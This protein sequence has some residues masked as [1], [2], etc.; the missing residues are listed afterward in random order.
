MSPARLFALMSGFLV[1]PALVFFAL[2]AAG[3]PPANESKRVIA[4]LVVDSN[5]SKIG[6]AVAKDGELVK[7]ALEDGFSK[8]KSRLVLHPILEGNKVTP[9]GVLDF[10]EKLKVAPT[11]TLLFYY[12]GHGAWD[13]TKGQY[14]QMYSGPRDKRGDLFRSTLITRLK[15]RKPRLLVCLTDCC[16]IEFDSRAPLTRDIKFPVAWDTIRR[17]LL[18][19]TG[20]VDMTSSAKGELSWT[21]PT[22]GGVPQGSLFTVALVDLLRIKPT[23]PSPDWDKAHAII[24]TWTQEDYSKFRKSVF[25]YYKKLPDE[26]KATLKNLVERLNK[27]EKQTVYR[28]PTSDR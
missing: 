28:Y 11:D 1:L 2:P 14:L 5:D 15:A 26:K 20:V 23:G 6:K 19:P 21:Y 9:D 25:D 24:K 4:V 8:E 18:L 22:R 16:N 3:D 17:L 7:Q 27:Q 12:S 10:I 13:T